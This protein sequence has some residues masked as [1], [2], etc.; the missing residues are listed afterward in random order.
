MTNQTKGGLSSIAVFSLKRPITIIMIFLS[1]VVVGLISSR[2]LLLEKMPAMKFPFVNVNVAYPS[3]T[4][5]EV[6]QT[7]TRLL[8]ESV[9]TIG[10]IKQINSR[11]S[12]NGANVGIAFNSD[13]DIDEKTMLVKE[14]VDL[15]RPL[16]PDDV[17]RIVIN[18]AE[19]GNDSIMQ[20]RIT[21]DLDLENAYDLIN[22]YLVRPVERVAGVSKVDF[23]GIE[24]KELR[25]I[26]D[27]DALKKYKIGFNELLQKLQDVNFAIASGNFK[28]GNDENAMQIRVVPKG[29]INDIDKLK[30]VV[31]NAFGIRLSDVAK[32]S[33][34][35]GDRN[36]ARHLDRKYSVGLEIYKESTAN[37][38]D[39]A[40]RVLQKIDEI[41]QQPQ[42]KGLKLVFLENQALSV[43]TSLNDVISAGVVGA[44]LSLLVLYFF[45]RDLATTLLVSLS[46]PI[47]IIITLGA[48]YFLGISLN[49]LSLMGL[50]LAIGMLV[51]NSVVISESILTKRNSG[52]YSIVGAIQAGVSEV[53]VPVIAGTVTS[54]CIFLPIIFGSG[55]LLYVFMT[56]VAAS[57]VAAMIISLFLAITVVPLIISKL[58][59]KPQT[60]KKDWFD[61]I[62][63][64]YLRI[65]SFSLNHRWWTFFFIVFI[66]VLGAVSSKFMKED[67]GIGPTVGREFWLPYH[68]DGSFTLERMKKDVDK[69]EDYLYANKER[70]EIRTVYSYYSE[71]NF[72]GTK[73]YL[74][75]EDEAKKSVSEIKK[76][77]IKDL[78]KI[79][80]GTPSFRWRRGN[81]ANNNSMSIYL[82]GDSHEVLNELLPSILLSL[83][84]VDGVSGASVEN[85]NKREE[86]QI[87]V[88]R[89]RAIRL[90]VDPNT[91]ARSIMIA[92][93]GMN[94]REIVTEDGELPVIMRFYKTGE[95]K[96]EQLTD[97]PIKTARGNQVSLSTVATINHTKSPQIIKRHNRQGSV[98]IDIDLEDDVNKKDIKKEF[99]AIMD[100][101]KFPSGY[102]WTFDANTRDMGVQMET[103][104]HVLKVAGALIFIVMAALFESL[105]FPLIVITSILFSYIGVILFFVITGTSFEIMAGIGMLILMGVVV[106]NGIVLIDHINQL[107]IKGMARRQAILQAGKD[108]L[109]PIM[110]TVATT[111]VGLIPLAVSTSSIGGDTN[112]PAY[113]PM[114][115]AIIGGLTFSTVVSLL[116]LPSLYCWFDDLRHWTADRFKTATIKGKLVKIP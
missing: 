24:P 22:R 92:M 97:L 48:L 7:I 100:K 20:I 31:V 65:L 90:G 50:M 64:R 103:I 60:D 104:F 11:S 44:F 112:M 96:M 30:N 12:T 98:Q 18:K 114:A 83:N 52:N 62:K 109:R 91:V 34:V 85:K 115:R 87:V 78:P 47:S 5:K 40:D 23:Q 113:F 67:E 106:N 26:I 49:V 51:D 55:D 21:G 1:L 43:K 33:L 95:F 54:V 37:M 75:D 14:Q 19:F 68:V 71:D 58:K 46:I 105:I 80:I 86:L 13:V 72:T 116:V 76:A 56:H 79:A 61:A 53:M 69:I 10:D 84:Q 63:N 29:Q 59:P 28:T 111:V 45:T 101:V 94:L 27:N 2:L 73:I 8:E 108:R 25:I 70:F 93:R 36:Y 3:S 110:M 74:T 82:Q 16:L 102:G 88:N 38:V 99:S 9:A 89:E 15:T 17:R 35:N 107:R 81:G 41:G 4:P 42:L 57:I 77:I 39:V 66:V 32:V 6:E